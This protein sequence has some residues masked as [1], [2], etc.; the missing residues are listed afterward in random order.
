MFTA[1]VQSQQIQAH[2]RKSI[3]DAQARARAFS[4]ELQKTE[5]R[6]AEQSSAAIDEWARLSRETLKYTTDLNAEW[7]K[8]ALEATKP[9]F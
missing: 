7:R 5:E 6:A 3:E 1:F 8:A 9:W 2:F 4:A